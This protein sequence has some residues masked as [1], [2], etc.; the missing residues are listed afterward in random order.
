MQL[1]LAGDELRGHF[2]IGR[3]SG[4]AA[5]YIR[6]DIMDL[7]AVLVSHD[8]VVRRTRVGAQN[9]AIFKETDRRRQSKDLGKL[10]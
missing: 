7:G 8:G 6:R 3:S 10:E 5:V 4:A 9:N 2:R 1:D